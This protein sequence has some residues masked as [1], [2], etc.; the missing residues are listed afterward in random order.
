L[1]SADWRLSLVGTGSKR[2]NRRNK[3]RRTA[4]RYRIFLPIEL[5]AASEQ[6]AQP[7]S[8]TTKDISVRGIYF[9]T[10]Q[11]LIPG[12]Q[13]DLRMVLPAQLVQGTEVLVLAQGKVVRAEKKIENGTERVGVA[14]GIETFDIVRP[15]S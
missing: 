2:P 13:L 4:H 10:E 8:A 1:K 15:K 6:K 14:V 12:S 9:T 7:L 5:S 11:E 3:E